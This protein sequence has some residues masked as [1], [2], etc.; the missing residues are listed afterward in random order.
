MQAMTASD[1]TAQLPPHNT[2]QPLSENQPHRLA[3]AL[4]LGDGIGLSAMEFGHPQQ[5]VQWQRY[6]SRSSATGCLPRSLRDAVW[7]RQ[8]EFIAGRCCAAHALQMAGLGEAIS[9]E[10]LAIDQDRL[11]QWPTGWLGSISHNRVGAIAIAAT[12]AKWYALGVDR[13]CLFG[14][15]MAREIATQIAS[16]QESR[17][18]ASLSQS[19]ARPLLPLQQTSLLFSA[20]EALYKALFPKIRCFQDFHAA[21][22]IALD[23]HLLRLQ[24]SHSWSDEWPTGSEIDVA[25]A[26]D[27][28]QIYTLVQVPCK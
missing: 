5:S 23:D 17:L 14:A 28:R 15:S 16:V 1:Q 8:H 12:C 22:V 3:Y 2:L 21:R 25:Y 11:P 10:M 24:L 6:L 4:G 27:E 26:L 19:L 20:K 13:E 7:Q 9:D 18:L